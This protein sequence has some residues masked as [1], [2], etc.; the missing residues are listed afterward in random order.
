[1]SGSTPIP[2]TPALIELDSDEFKTICSWPFVGSDSYVT[3]LLQNDVRQY[4]KYH[5]GRIWVYR[6]P[7]NRLVG[8]GT[9]SVSWDCRRLNGGRNHTYIP[10]L[11][12]NPTIKSL[13]F[14]TSIV[15]HLIDEAALLC[16]DT[17]GFFDV[18]FLDVYTTNT[19]AIE[20]Y[21]KFGFINLTDEPIQDTEEDGKTYIIM[22]KR[23]S[24][25]EI[26][27]PF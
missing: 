21:K 17:G 9:L 19:K 5:G 1:M 15:Q 27:D 7:D 13:G 24:T 20:L 6:D 22:A 23:V 3:R 4:V 25:P 14:G 2:L 18:L 8:F 11:A 12:V 10:L 26:A 16:F